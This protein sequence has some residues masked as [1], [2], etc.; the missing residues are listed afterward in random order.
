MPPH[1]ADEESARVRELVELQ[2]EVCHMNADRTL[3]TWTRTAL[4]LMV[5]GTVVDRFGLVMLHG[6]R[7]H[8]GTLFA[9]NPASGV[10]GLFLVGLGGALAFA[11]ALRYR[12]YRREWLRAYG[13]PGFHGP[14]LA[15]VLALM[16]AGA[17]LLLFVILLVFRR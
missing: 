15:F 13:H 5:F 3:A 1:H 2:A 4:S 8:V 9:Q 7:A 11:V 16:A 17:G 10:G 12:A 14:W 6:Q